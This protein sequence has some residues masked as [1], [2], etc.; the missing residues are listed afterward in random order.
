MSEAPDIRFYHLERS[1]LIDAL[2]ALL[3]KTLEAGAR[4]IVR[5]GSAERAEALSAELWTFDAASWLPHGTAKDGRAAEQPVWVTADDDV[6]NAATFLFLCDGA[7]AA[8]DV[9]SGF[10]RCFDLF[11]GRDGDAVAAA[12]GRWKA[13]TD[14][15]LSPAYWR[16]DQAGRWREQHRASSDGD[17]APE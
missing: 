16:Q 6:P 12:R 14:A 10:A 5:T 11:D 1:A 7:Q 2:P 9:V 13:L 15:G 4:A 17:A 8:P 3:G